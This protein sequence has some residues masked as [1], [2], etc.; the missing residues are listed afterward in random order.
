MTRDTLRSLYRGNMDGLAPSADAKVEDLRLRWARGDLTTA[1]ISPQILGELTDLG[2]PWATHAFRHF[3]RN[4][5]IRHNYRQF[6]WRDAAKAETGRALDVLAAVET[7]VLLRAQK[8]DLAKVQTELDYRH[9]DILRAAEGCAALPVVM[10]IQRYFVT[11]A[12][13]IGSLELMNRYTSVNKASVCYAW[14]EHLTAGDI[15]DLADWIVLLPE[16]IAGT[17]ACKAAHLCHAIK[18]IPFGAHLPDLAAA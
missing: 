2:E 6:L 5:F 11:L 14:A 7:A 1:E 4:G 3:E 17:D 12:V 15:D 10:A 16:L 8:M 18:S 9:A 13:S